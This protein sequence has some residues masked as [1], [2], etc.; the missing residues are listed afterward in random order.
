[1]YEL[2]LIKCKACGRFIGGKD[3]D[4]GRCKSWRRY[5]MV[6]CEPIEDCW[7]CAECSKSDDDKSD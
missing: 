5:D 1:M 6:A 7:L 2:T 4:E 3:L